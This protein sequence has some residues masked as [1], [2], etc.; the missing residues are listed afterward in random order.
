M[1]DSDNRSTADPIARS[2]STR[3]GKQ[4]SAELRAFRAIRN[5]GICP[6]DVRGDVKAGDAGCLICATADIGI[7]C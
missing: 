2:D 6:R 5:S 4:S 7:G 3:S 1:L